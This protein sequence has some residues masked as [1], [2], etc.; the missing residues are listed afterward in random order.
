MSGKTYMTN[1]QSGFALVTVLL[2][3]SLMAVIGITLNR[4]G[5]LQSTISFN[6]KAGDEAYYIANAGVQHAL[7]K[8]TLDSSL[9]GTVF[10]NEPFGAGSYT[11]TISDRITPMGALLITSTGRCGA[12][13]RTIK[14]YH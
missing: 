8:L 3:V 9:R 10:T 4:T 6:L 11:V 5:G 12:A 14:K 13:A 7:F 2:L 1:S